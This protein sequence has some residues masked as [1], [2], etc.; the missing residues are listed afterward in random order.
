[1]LGSQVQREMPSLLG[2]HTKFDALCSILTNGIG[3][4]QEVCLWAFSN[5]CKNDSEEIN[6]GLRLQSLV[7]DKLKTIS[8]ASLFQKAGGY[9]ESAS[10]SFMEGES[11]EYMKRMYGSFRLNFDLRGIEQFGFADFLDCEYVPASELDSYGKEYAEMVFDLYS[12]L[13]SKKDSPKRFAP[14]HLFKVIEY[15]YMDIDLVRKPL[16]IKEARW[17]EEREWRKLLQIKPNDKDICYSGEKP[18]KKV[19]Y[20][21][22]SLKDITILFEQDK[23]KELITNYLRLMVFLVS[24]PMLWGI[25][26]K[27]KKV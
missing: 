19:Y 2:H 9:K 26:I 3:K 27:T 21:L 4:D 8:D 13:L 7:N 15:L 18:Y 24:H 23:K 6:M 11:T 5:M 20:P 17:S 1:M 25:R 12:G 16:I 14:E 10:L 22:S